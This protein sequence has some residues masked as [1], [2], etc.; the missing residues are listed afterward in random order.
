MSH[1]S[2][3]VRVVAPLLLAMGSAAC[4]ARPAALTGPAPAASGYTAWV[5]NEASDLVTRLHYT[6]GGELTVVRSI[7][8]GV[9]GRIAGP[10]GIAASPD[11]RYWYVSLSHG[12]PF[13][14]VRKYSTAADTALAAVGVGLF[15]E[16]IA[17]TPDGQYLFLTN[18]DLHATAQISGIS[19]VYTP[20]MTEVARPNTC[21]RPQGGRMNATAVT[22]FSVCG[23]TDQLV[24]IDARS[25]AV[26]HRYS[27]T[28]RS[29]Q[30]VGVDERVTP[31]PGADRCA[32]AWAEPGRGARAG[33]VYVACRAG[34]QVVEIDAV[35]WQVTRRFTFEAPGRMATDPSGALLLVA[36]PADSAVIVL[37]LDAATHQR[38]ATSRQGPRGIAVTADGRYA[39][40]ANE[41]AGAAR[42]TVDVIDLTAR[43]RVA[44][45]DVAYSPAAIDVTIEQ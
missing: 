3:L 30:S 5:A 29:E 23:R 41:G 10:H 12:T 45:V 13:G 7:G 25:F 42:G 14:R 38:I 16:T 40:I 21:P 43:A 24:A 9:P 19:V 39:F 27:L 6:P 18:Q 26:V 37:N 32:P 11:G 33:L 8:V 2:Q 15:P 34:D 17:I 22:H 31:A 36:L 28:P 35:T 4:A 44:S 1:G 20:T